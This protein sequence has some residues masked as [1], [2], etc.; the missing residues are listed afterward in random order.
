MISACKIISTDGIDRLNT[1]LLLAVADGFSPHG[2]I[3]PIS[4]GDLSIVMVDTGTPIDECKVI[5]VYGMVRLNELLGDVAIAGYYPVGRVESLP[6]N[7]FLVVVAKGGDSGGG[8]GDIT[9]AQ[10]TDAT[11]TG[12]AVL[13]AANAGAARTAI[14]AGTSSLAIGT[15]STTA[16]AGDYQPTAAN[17]SDATAV[18]RSVMTA[19]DAAAARTA[20]GAGIGNSNLV[21]GTSATQAKAGNYQ[22]TAA[23]I[24]D[25]GAFGRQLLQAADQAAAKALLGIA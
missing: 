25:A 22:P 7:K 18:G 21:V 8:G 9:S 19:A 11:D 4:N 12:K 5:E 24:S 17:I 16:K 15:T 14:G 6:G 1:L 23:N 3:I 13:T 2:S 10:I 20:I